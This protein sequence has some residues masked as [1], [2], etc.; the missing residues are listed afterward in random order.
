VKEEYINVVNWN[1]LYRFSEN[2]SIS[3]FVFL[4]TEL[5]MLVQTDLR[6]ATDQM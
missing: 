2:K 3:K 5:Q 1:Q 4:Y 6:L